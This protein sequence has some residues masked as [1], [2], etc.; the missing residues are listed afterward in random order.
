MSELLWAPWEALGKV[1]LSKEQEGLEIQLTKEWIPTEDFE[2][3]CDCLGMIL[4]CVA[5]DGEGE[6][7]DPPELEQ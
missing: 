4:S 5:E 3:Q 7:R 2:E 1:Q 6:G